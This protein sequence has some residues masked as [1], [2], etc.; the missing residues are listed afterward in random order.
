MSMTGTSIPTAK[1]DISQLV[2]YGLL[3]QVEGSAGRNTRYTI[4]IGHL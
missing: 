4:T 1:R 2:A 3:H